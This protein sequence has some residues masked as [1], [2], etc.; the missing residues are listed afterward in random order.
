MILSGQ[1]V[2]NSI[3]NV[4]GEQVTSISF[5]SGF[6]FN[7]WDAFINIAGPDPAVTA[8]AVVDSID[9][10]TGFIKPNIGHTLS[11]TDSVRIYLNTQTVTFSAPPNPIIATASTTIDSQGRVNSFTLTNP[12]TNY[13]SNP[14]VTIQAPQTAFP[15]RATAS[16]TM[17]NGAIAAIPITDSGAYYDSSGIGISATVN[18][19]VCLLYTSD[20]ADE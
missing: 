20:A 8:T 14:T 9:S 1:A 11:I 12:G 10:N 2:T 19:T 18:Y 16:L 13:R 6:G 17:S 3:A 7:T 5:D 4:V 15:K